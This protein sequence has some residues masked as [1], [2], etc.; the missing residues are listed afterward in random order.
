MILSERAKT[1]LRKLK[2]IEKW[3]KESA[4][5]REYFIR[6]NLQV[7]EILVK[8]QENFS[9]YKLSIRNKSEDTFLLSL[10][11]KTD[12]EQNNKIELCY[13]DNNY[14]IDFGEH[15][16]AQ[17]NFYITDLGEI[18][19]L[20]INEDDKPNIIC[21]SVEKFI[22]QYALQDELTNQT[23]SKYYYDIINNEQLSR[24]IA[25]GFNEMRE[26]SDN[27]SHWYSNGQLTIVQG[28]WLDRA[29]F[30]LHVYGQNEIV[31]ND[32]IEN[33]K[34]ANVV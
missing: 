30:Y 2:R 33:L 27:Y 6:Q 26:C 34:K 24:I 10:F 8:I 22:E 11:S 1:Y 15:Q 5:T 20:G 12:I 4:A 25:N 21:S 17:F 7:N 31:C 9:G 3:Q 28:I 19:T 23:E 14:L 29:E 16:T 18:C 32:F 13:F